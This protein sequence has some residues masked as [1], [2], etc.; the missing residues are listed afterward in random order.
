MTRQSRVTTLPSHQTDQT[1]IPTGYNTRGVV[2]NMRNCQSPVSM[3]QSVSESDTI[4]SARDASTSEKLPLLLL[5]S[6]ISSIR[7]IAVKLHVKKQQTCF[8]Q[9]KFELNFVAEKPCW[10]KKTLSIYKIHRPSMFANKSCQ[11]IF[12]RCIRTAVNVHISYFLHMY[13]IEV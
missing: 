1:N 2:S 8:V 4:I 3:S 10:T 6:E 12:S 5:F 9:M 11:P 13:S 7:A